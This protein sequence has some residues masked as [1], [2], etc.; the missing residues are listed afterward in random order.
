MV[1]FF[2]NVMLN[3][4]T[5]WNDTSRPLGQCAFIATPGVKVHPAEITPHLRCLK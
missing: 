1:I 5:M 3:H 2:G 4:I